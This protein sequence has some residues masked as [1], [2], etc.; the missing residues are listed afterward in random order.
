MGHRS[1]FVRRRRGGGIA[2]DDAGN[3]YTA[4]GFGNLVQF[5]LDG[6][7][8]G[9]FGPV[10]TSATYNTGNSYLLKQDPNGKLVW[11]QRFGT[12]DGSYAS[13]GAGANCIAVDGAG[14]NIYVGGLFRARFGTPI[15]FSTSQ[16]QSLL[17]TP[18]GFTDLFVEK[19][20][21]SG[22]PVWAVR[23]GSDSPVGQESLGESA[24]GIALDPQGKS[25]A[26]NFTR[27]AEPS[28][29]PSHR[30]WRSDAVVAKLDR[31]QFLWRAYWRRAGNDLVMLSL[32]TMAVSP[33]ATSLRPRTGRRPARAAAPN[34]IGYSTP[35]PRRPATANSVLV[36][37]RPDPRC[38]H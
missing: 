1:R 4:G 7:N 23:A 34:P 15:D 16:D 19:F 37:R 11:V 2:V 8:Q 14:A 27:N 32:S 22:T 36:N 33:T 38:R 26:G 35:R 31:A 28:A 10:I 30:R 17:L 5:E 25:T 24:N 3:I 29:I 18:S 12:S 20:D 13:D 6:T 9:H 21:G